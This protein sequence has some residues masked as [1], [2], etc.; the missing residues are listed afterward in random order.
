MIFLKLYRYFLEKKKLKIERKISWLS[1]SFFSVYLLCFAQINATG[2]SIQDDIAY[3]GI[4]QGFESTWSSQHRLSKIGSGISSSQIQSTID[5]E[6]K[7][8]L[9]SVEHFHLAN[10]EGKSDRMGFT[11]HLT[12]VKAPGLRTYSDTAVI[13]FDGKEGKKHSKDLNI[14]I[15][16]KN[17]IPNLSEYPTFINGF[18]LISE[19]NADHIEDFWIQIQDGYWQNETVSID[20]NAKIRVNCKGKGCGCKNKFRYKLKIYFSVFAGNQNYAFSTTTLTRRFFWDKRQEPA[21]DFAP[22]E[23]EGDTTGNYE[24]AIPVFK[25]ISFQF[26]RAY[27]FVGWNM[28]LRNINYN[29]KTR[30]CTF[31]PDFFFQ[32]WAN[33]NRDSELYNSDT[34]KSKRK[35]GFYNINVDLGLIQLMKGE[36]FY[37]KTPGQIRIRTND[38]D[39]YPMRSQERF[40]SSFRRTF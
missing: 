36:A 23:F 17:L 3:F 39:N 5:G 29:P 6:K 34:K 10:N 14:L 18:E 35:L 31:I 7:Q 38:L 13:F 15:S 11:S 37:Y 33:I 16:G 30:T 9:L 40:L 22:F 2:Q 20:L 24:V 27:P 25:K 4:W 1:F 8:S 26:D 32:Q 28:A 21:N 12:L 19:E